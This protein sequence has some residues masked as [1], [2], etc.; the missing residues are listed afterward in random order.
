MNTTTRDAELVKVPIV[1]E[2]GTTVD[3]KIK[4]NIGIITKLAPPPQIELIQKAKI[5][6]R[7]RNNNFNIISHRSFFDKNSYF[8]KKTNT[9]K[10]YCHYHSKIVN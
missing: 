7:N 9:K 5:V 10:L 2:K 3:G 4:F 8:I 6:P 1:R